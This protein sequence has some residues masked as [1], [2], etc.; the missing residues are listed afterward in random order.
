MALP[1]A[2]LMASSADLVNLS[3]AIETLAFQSPLP[4]IFTN[5]FLDARP[6][7]T[8]T[9]RVISPV[10]FLVSIKVWMVSRL[11]AL[12]SFLLTFL[13]PNLAIFFAKASV[14]LRNRFSENIR[15]WLFDLCDLWLKYHRSR[16]PALCR[17]FLC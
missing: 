12:N 1:P 14:R 4:R 11:M 5:S 8:K 15:L 6:F 3:A 10:M 13:K 2:L 7:S 17:F 16:F 9:S